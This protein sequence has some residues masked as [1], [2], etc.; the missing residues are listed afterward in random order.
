MAR[1][2]EKIMQA[3][4]KKCRGKVALMKKIA[5]KMKDGKKLGGKWQK[6]WRW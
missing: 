1:K 3:K 6:K 5:E 2:S 4:M